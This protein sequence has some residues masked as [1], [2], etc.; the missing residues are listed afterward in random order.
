MPSIADLESHPPKGGN[1]TSFKKGYRKPGTF[2]A[3]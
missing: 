1:V 3:G 2:V